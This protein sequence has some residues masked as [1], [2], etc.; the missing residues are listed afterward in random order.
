MYKCIASLGLLAATI[1]SEYEVVR[2]RITD[3]YWTQRKEK[4]ASTTN[5]FNS[6]QVLQSFAIVVVVVAKTQPKIIPKK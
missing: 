1:V 6:N 4:T 3:N 2:F 5:N